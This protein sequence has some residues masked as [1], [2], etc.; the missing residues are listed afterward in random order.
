MREDLLLVAVCALGL[1]AFF[2]AKSV[3]GGFRLTEIKLT[4]SDGAAG[5]RFGD[6][7]AAS[8]NIIVVGARR[9]DDNGTNSG[10]VYVFERHGGAFVEVAKLTASDGAPD[11]RFGISVAAFGS[12]IVIGAGSDDD[13]GTNSGSAYV[14]R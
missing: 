6:R 1:M 11:D 12:H 8:E 9:D 10:S 3:S 13:D 4:A 14:F 5:D 7:L 2:S